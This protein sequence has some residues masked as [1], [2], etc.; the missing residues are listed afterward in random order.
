MSNDYQLFY[1]EQAG[2]LVWFNAKLNAQRQ[3][4]ALQHA[5]TLLSEP[6][7]VG[8]WFDYDTDELQNLDNHILFDAKTG[9]AYSASLQAGSARYILTQDATHVNGPVRAEPESMGEAIKLI[10]DYYAHHVQFNRPQERVNSETFALIVGLYTAFR[11]SDPVWTAVKTRLAAILKD[12]EWLEKFNQTVSAETDK[13]AANTLPPSPSEF[14]KPHYWY[15]TQDVDKIIGKQLTLAP[16]NDA[17]GA[18]LKGDKHVYARHSMRLADVTTDWFN[19]ELA[20][21]LAAT[22]NKPAQE[23][24][25]GFLI[26]HANAHWTA[27]R[28]DANQFN[29][30]TQRYDAVVVT[31]FDSLTNTVAP[32]LIAAIQGAFGVQ[33]VSVHVKQPDGSCCG[34]LSTDWLEKTLNAKAYNDK[35]VQTA[36]TVAALRRAQQQLFQ[37]QAPAAQDSESVQQQTATV[38]SEGEKGIAP[39]IT[40]YLPY[41]QKVNAGFKAEGNQAVFSSKRQFG[42]KQEG[43]VS[44]RVDA[45]G[46]VQISLPEGQDIP[47][48]ILRTSIRAFIMAQ[49]ARAYPKA[50]PDELAKKLGD[51]ENQRDDYLDSINAVGAVAIQAADPKVRQHMMDCAE[52]VFHLSIEKPAVEQDK[53]AKEAQEEVHAPRMAAAAA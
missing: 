7:V 46:K 16:F 32:E 8:E 27:L 48:D 29:V 2:Q 10:V 17:W 39:K 53:L 5:E 42:D 9:S 40:H 28:V 18:S 4:I 34:V 44:V 25:F 6:S 50:S 33:A 22:Q 19:Q 47:E 45:N 31:V 30:A 52:K 21:Y 43:E 11:S 41:F 3:I 12:N 51:I 36:A 1:A 24:S 38:E 26:N 35:Q 14:T 37:A 49:L 15:T 13:R 23:R 20:N